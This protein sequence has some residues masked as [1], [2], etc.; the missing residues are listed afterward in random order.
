MS[1]HT[2]L[3]RHLVAALLALA[4]GAGLALL[5]ADTT[6]TD[7]LSRFLTALETR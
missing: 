5:T 7:A 2:P 3:W 1:P 6:L 4:L